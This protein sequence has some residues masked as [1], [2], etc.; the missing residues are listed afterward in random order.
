MTTEL[1]TALI[2]TGIFATFVGIGIMVWAQ[3]I[4]DPSETA[5]IFSM[6]SVFAGV[7]AW[8]YAGEILSLMGW[9]GGLL[10]V[11]SVIWA[12]TG[13]DKKEVNPLAESVNTSSIAII[14]LIS[15]VFF[16]LYSN[17]LSGLTNISKF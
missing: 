10:V 13:G 1:K 12:E 2:V 7:F 17:A 5:I 9:I 6:E 8:L 3:K 4:L 16:S 11:S 15:P 14:L